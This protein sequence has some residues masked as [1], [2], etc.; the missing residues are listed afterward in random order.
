MA[1]EV[2]SDGNP[3]FIQVR[4]GRMLISVPKAIFKGRTSTLVASEAEVFKK[5]LASRYPWLSKRAIEVILEEAMS[6]MESI[7]DLE[8][9]EV[10][11]ARMLFAKGRLQK[12]LSS[13]EE[14]LRIDPEDADAWY[15]KGEILFKLGDK[16]QGYKAFAKARSCSSGSPKPA[17]RHRKAR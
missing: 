10:E 14:R 15:L 17:T 2:G 5:R 8:R 3:N 13:V 11:K 12:A 1:I 6:T 9:S 4:H 16:E 7:L